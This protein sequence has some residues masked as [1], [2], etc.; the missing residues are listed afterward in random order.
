MDINQQVESIVDGLVRGIE[1]R[2]EARLE[3]TV[4]KF[5]ATK[6]ESFDYEKKLN[7]LASVKLD[8]LISGLEI[9]KSTVEARINSVTDVVVGNIDSEL[10]RMSTDVLRARL[11]EIDVNST[12]RDIVINEI[13][14]RIDTTEF[15]DGSIPAKSINTAGLVLSGNAIKGGMIQNFS[16]SGIEDKSSQVQMT[17]LNEA[18]VIENKIVTLGLN[19]QGTTVLDGDLVIN[20]SVPRDSQFY[21]SILENAIVGVKE[22]MDE[23]F[24]G[25]YSA[26]I[27]NKIKEEGLDLN[28]ISLNGQEII[29]GNKL[30]YG[31]V[32][33]N[34]T[35]LG[36][37]RDLQTNG[38]TYLSEHLY[39]GKNKVG[40]G[41]IEPGHSLTV[42]DQEVEIGFGKRLKDTAW[43]GT[44]RNQE[45]IISANNQDNLKLNTDG[46]VSIK[47]LNVAKVSVMSAPSLPNWAEPKGTVA[48][49]ENPGIGQPIG[50]V[51]LGNGAWSKFGSIT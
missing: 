29:S 34:I 5:L 30:N 46:S 6:L 1:T 26:V 22:S 48:F 24:F 23:S 13:G 44:P 51:S 49:N 37:V 40:I 20:G 27:F 41:T 17:L 8:G 18:V 25:D 12:L 15:P 16:S 31:I 9:N 10:R 33:T 32:D 50:W 39:V 19:V 7:W 35:R 2:L 11:N 45:L 21:N 38:E 42:W 4:N 36:S 14:R 47:R 28:R 3:Q 43:M